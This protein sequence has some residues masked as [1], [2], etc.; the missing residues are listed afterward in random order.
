MR[1]RTWAPQRERS[2]AHDCKDQA[3][4]REQTPRSCDPLGKTR[5]DPA[6]CPGCRLKPS[7]SRGWSSPFKRSTGSERIVGT[8]SMELQM[9]LQ[10]ALP[11][12]AYTLGVWASLL[13]V[14]HC[15]VTPGVLSFSTFAAV[16]ALLGAFAL[17]NGFREHGC[18]RILVL[19]VGG[20]THIAS[21][22]CFGDRLPSHSVEVAVTA[23]GSAFMITAH[24]LNH[25][26]CSRCR[27]C[28]PDAGSAC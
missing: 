24:R 27:R 28:L 6:C 22:A 17:V 16:I 14:A 19:M 21:A 8:G 9:N 3:S 4:S 20:L 1:P 11:R 15:I 18:R 26:F 12:S 13:C 2:C 5:S 10:R 25:T 7:L 23:L